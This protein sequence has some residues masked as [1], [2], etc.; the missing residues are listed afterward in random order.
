MLCFCIR[1]TIDGI[2]DCSNGLRRQY[3]N[4]VGEPNGPMDSQLVTACDN[5]DVPDFDFDT[6]QHNTYMCCWTENDG[7]GMQDNTVSC[8]CSSVLLGIPSSHGLVTTQSCGARSCPTEAP[9]QA[10]AAL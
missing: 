8:F 1:F 3:L 2:T 9:F 4:W 5:V 6:C 10:S 7:Q